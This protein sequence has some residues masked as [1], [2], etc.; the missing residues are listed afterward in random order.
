MTII[1]RQLPGLEKRFMVRGW[2]AAGAGYAVIDRVN[3]QNFKR[4]EAA[5]R[6]L[7]KMDGFDI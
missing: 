3:S 4:L 5:T 6:Q 1:L 7:V 2:F